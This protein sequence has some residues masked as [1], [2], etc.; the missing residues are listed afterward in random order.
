MPLLFGVVAAIEAVLAAVGDAFEQFVRRLA[1]V[2]AEEFLGGAPRREVRIGIDEQEDV[3]VADDRTDDAAADLALADLLADH[4]QPFRISRL[5]LLDG[6]A[7]LEFT[8]P[9]LL[10]S[11]LGVSR[12]AEACQSARHRYTRQESLHRSS[13]SGLW[14]L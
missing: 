8:G 1:L 2:T 6:L 7:F 11:G 9:N 14:L 13:P 3:R 10:V 12:H 4:R 5:D